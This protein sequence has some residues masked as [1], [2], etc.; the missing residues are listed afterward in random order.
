MF[1]W[2]GSKLAD[3]ILDRFIESK[4]NKPKICCALEYRDSEDLI[5]VEF[6]NKTSETGYSVKIY[7]VGN[8]PIIIENVSIYNNKDI[9]VGYLEFGTDYS[10][11]LHPYE[12]VLCTVM[13]QDLDNLE[14]HISKL[15]KSTLELHVTS[16]D[17]KEVTCSLDLQIIKMNVDL[18]DRLYGSK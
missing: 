3:L 12:S 5:P 16:V 10:Y 4:K 2:L 1:E 15:K 11:T 14:W 18:R 8:V 17:G 13:Q 9:I 6:R 7:N